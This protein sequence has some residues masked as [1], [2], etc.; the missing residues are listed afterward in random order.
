MN[1]YDKPVI[2]LGGK[3]Q[4]PPM[5]R[6]ARLKAG[7]LVRMLQGGDVVS[8]PDSRPMALIGPH[9]HELRVQDADATWRIIYRLDPEAI[10]L[11]DIFSKKTQ[12]TPKRVIETCQARLKAFDERTGG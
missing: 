2:W 6:E 8:M 10:V 5:S 3:I 1:P 4:S 11:V 7:F 12:K 9:C